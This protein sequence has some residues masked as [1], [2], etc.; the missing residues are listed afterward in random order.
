MDLVAYVTPMN[1]VAVHRMN[2]Q[3]LGVLDVQQLI[4]RKLDKSENNNK[5]ENNIEL[6]IITSLEWHPN[7]IFIYLFIRNWFSL[8]MNKLLKK[9]MAVFF[10]IF[11]KSGRS[12]AI[13]CRYGLIIAD[14]ENFKQTS[15]IF[16]K[17]QSKHC[18]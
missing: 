16:F 7:G 1:Q 18:F 9:K 10:L 5:N 3:K 8:H 11:W 6:F 12:L 2:W 17:N 13:G 14:I 15:N 4:S